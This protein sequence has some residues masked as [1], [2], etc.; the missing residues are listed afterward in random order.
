MSQVIK[1]IINTATIIIK[2]IPFLRSASGIELVRESLVD[3]IVLIEGLPLPISPPDA[4]ELTGKEAA[5]SYHK[6]SLPI[7]IKSTLYIINV[8]F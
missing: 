5:N 6:F 3:V 7:I 2:Q 4:I 8:P 1:Q